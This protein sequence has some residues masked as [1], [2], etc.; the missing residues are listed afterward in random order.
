[1]QG[2]QEGVK[3]PRRVLLKEVGTFIDFGCKPFCLYVLIENLVLDHV[4]CKISPN[5]I[6][7]LLHWQHYLFVS[8]LDLKHMMV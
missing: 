4:H 1:M 5:P 2:I 7:I 3:E 8:N 6:E